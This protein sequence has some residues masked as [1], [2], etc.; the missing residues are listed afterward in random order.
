MHSAHRLFI[1]AQAI[2]SRHWGERGIPR[3]TA[4]LCRALLRRDSLVAAIVLDPYTPRPDWLD[5]ELAAAPQVTRNTVHAF[6][7]ALA[8]G[9]LAY[10]VMSPFETTAAES[11]VPPYVRESG[12]PIVAVLYDLIPDVLSFFPDGSF[13]DRQYRLR[14]QWL[15]HADLILSLSEHTKRDAVDR[16]RVAPERV[17][18]IGAGTDD[19]FFRPPAAADDPTDVIARHVPALNRPFVLSVAGWA[20]HK[21]TETLIDAWANV[22]TEIRRAHQLVIVCS[23]PDEGRHAWNDRARERGLGGGEVILTGHIDDHVLRALYQA[24][25]VFVLPSRYEGFGL[26][27]L[28]AAR[29]GCPVITSNTSS[30][31][32]VL[33]WP[34]ATF[35]ADDAGA[36]AGLLGR[37]LLD[38]RFR[39]RLTAASTAAAQR[40]TWERVA[41]RV[42][43]ACARLPEPR[44]RPRRTPIRIALVGP[45]PPSATGVAAFNERLARHLAQYCD[46]DCFV[47]STSRRPPPTSRTSG[48][49]PISALGPVR[50][51]ASYDA[52]IYTV[53]DSPY[54]LDTY[55]AA[56]RYPG[57]VWFH[58]VSLHYL[59]LGIAHRLLPEAGMAF[60]REQLA[61][62]GD[63]VPPGLL[64]HPSWEDPQPYADAGIHFAAELA[65]KDR[66]RIVSSR[67][68]QTLL[69]TDV[70]PSTHAAPTWVLPHPAPH[71]HD[72]DERAERA[73]QPLV[74]ALGNVHPF[75]Q[76][77]ALIRAVARIRTV[78]PA[79]VAFVG[80]IVEPGYDERLRQYAETLGVADAVE[81]T[82]YVDE[83]A[84]R[85]WIERAHCVVALR[86]AE[87]GGSSGAVSDALAAGT[88]VVTNM[89]VYRELPA[90]TVE[91]LDP[92]ATDAGL[93][94][95]IQRVLADDEHRGRLEAGAR[96]YSAGWSFGSL[97][98]ALVEIARTDVVGIA[99]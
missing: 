25:E 88:A 91:L 13:A 70:G 46:L 14:R 9:P 89:P 63:R 90:G 49:F 22:A 5:P 34:P 26:P 87:R 3:Y 60:L 66:G 57:I 1:D 74:L 48:W 71:Q 43:D 40:H 36:L 23:L 38:E 86:A 85:R 4:G 96:R 35:P 8:A 75:K 78:L 68:A 56:L 73:A 31:P 10:V 98:L 83:A 30:L 93:A 95:T 28:E 2:Q 45:F 55:A 17:A 52:L 65:T 99:G 37:A 50:N 84:Y 19:A 97:S 76:P 16:L 77:E 67:R 53:G 24:A 62:Y 80:S 47:E 12:V 64:Q 54:H 72:H 51:P 58:D 39:R 29:C 59:Y 32:E 20:P 82:G 81:V 7:R 27:V 21:N 18:V 92:D 69:D 41:N 11:I 44:A 61:R 94:N 33:D 15:R 6:R 42:E 79:R